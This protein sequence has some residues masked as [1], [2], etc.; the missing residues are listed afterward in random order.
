MRK[1]WSFLVISLCSL[2]LSAESESVW[3]DRV[4]QDKYYQILKETETALRRTPGDGAA[5]FARAVALHKVYAFEEAQENFRKAAQNG[6]RPSDELGN[7]SFEDW[8]SMND[9]CARVLPL[10]TSVP[11]SSRGY[12]IGVRALADSRAVKVARKILPALSK[13]AQDFFGVKADRLAVFIL[14]DPDALDEFWE[15]TRLSFGRPDMERGAAAHKV[16]VLYFENLMENQTDEQIA[17]TLAHELGHVMHT[18]RNKEQALYGSQHPAWWVEGIATQFATR[19][20]GKDRAW[21]TG[22][23]QKEMKRVGSLPFSGLTGDFQDNNRSRLHYRTA[24]M[25]IGHLIEKHGR[26]ALFKIIDRVAEEDYAEAPDVLK[27]VAGISAEELFNRVVGPA[28]EQTGIHDEGPQLKPDA[29]DYIPGDAVLAR[30]KP[31]GPFEPAMMLSK[32]GNEAY[33]RFFWGGQSRVPYSTNVR[34]F[35]WKRGMKVRCSKDSDSDKEIVTIEGMKLENLL[36]RFPSGPREL[37]Y[38]R[39]ED[40][41]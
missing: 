5:L 6:A 1:R 31:G 38:E 16:T 34:K 2:S 24:S 7:V 37:K 20:Q 39:C 8:N 32:T 27:D 25:M 9:A 41:R 33:I 3:N 26:E 23:W 11:A 29:R 18:L 13:Q 28:R 4:R 10:Q 19:F 30:D 12:Q 35:D 22:E 21:E 40:L 15:E 17:E 14:K 36:V